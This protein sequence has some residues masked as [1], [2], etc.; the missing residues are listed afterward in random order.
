MYYKPLSKMALK[1]LYYNLGVFVSWWQVF[2]V[3]V[4]LLLRTAEPQNIEPKNIE[5]MYS[6]NFIKSRATCPLVPQ[7]ALLGWRASL[8]WQAGVITSFYI[9]NSLFDIRYLYFTAGYL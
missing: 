9:R 7:A 2:L 1:K 5:G 6:G 4:R 8:Q 3:P